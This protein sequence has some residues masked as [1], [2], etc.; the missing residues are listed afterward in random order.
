MARCLGIKFYAVDAAGAPLALGKVYTYEPGGTTAKKTYANAALTA[1][2]ANPV[3]LD[4]G[5][6]AN[7][8]LNGVTKMVLKTAAGVTVTTVDKVAGN[9]A[10]TDD[11][12]TNTV[13]VQ[14]T[15]TIGNDLTGV[16]DIIID[17]ALTVTGNLTTSVGSTH[18]LYGTVSVPTMETT[19]YFELLYYIT[20]VQVTF[21]AAI[22]A[23]TAVNNSMFR[24]SSSGKLTI[25]DNAGTAYDTY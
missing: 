8:Y 7:I 23:G 3:I 22:A 2:N 20:T 10:T 19:A 9:A 24:D 6:Q 13:I 16:E 17:G 1:E 5:G 21:S 15:T 18:T 25:K 11:I 4:A 12:V 14:N